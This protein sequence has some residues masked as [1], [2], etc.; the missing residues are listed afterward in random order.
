MT[1]SM[2]NIPAPACQ[3]SCPS[4]PSGCLDRAPLPAAWRAVA[5]CGRLAQC[6][7][8]PPKSPSLSVSWS[9]KGKH[10]HNTA[11]TGGSGMT[12]HR[13]AVCSSTLIH[14]KLRKYSSNPVNDSIIV[15]RVPVQLHAILIKGCEKTFKHFAAN[16]YVWLHGQYIST[17]S[18]HFMELHSII[19]YN[20]HKR[21]LLT[22]RYP[23]GWWLP[24]GPETFSWC[25]LRKVN[26]D[27]LQCLWTENT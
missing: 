12:D 23:W 20:T 15:T 13:Y 27:H 7:T 9:M 10:T 19:S 17:C 8:R 16:V 18:A 6:R 5:E 1:T 26:R 25:R 24:E 21:T 3:Q 4:W 22:W 2:L 14:S 11:E